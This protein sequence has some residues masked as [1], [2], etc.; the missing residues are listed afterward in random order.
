MRNLSFLYSQNKS[1]IDEIKNLQLKLSASEREFHDK[2][3][4]QME[5]E[6]EKVSQISN[7]KSDVSI[8]I[9]QQNFH[10]FDIIVNVL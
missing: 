4:I 1:Y 6:V 9:F 2:L 5:C 3:R 8:R 10:N 7:E